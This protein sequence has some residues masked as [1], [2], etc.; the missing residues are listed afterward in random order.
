MMRHEPGGE[1]TELEPIGATL[2]VAW[3]SD[4]FRSASAPVFDLADGSCA[5]LAA[6]PAG[7]SPARVQQLLAEAMRKAPETPQ[8]LRLV[9]MRVMRELH[10]R[11]ESLAAAVTRAGSTLVATTPGASVV[12]VRGT[13]VLDRA[14]DAT[15]FETQESD[16]IALLCNKL[17]PL[18]GD[19]DELGRIIGADDP[20]STAVTLVELG[21][22]RGGG[23]ELSAVVAVVGGDEL[24]DTTEDTGSFAVDDLL[25][26]LAPTLDGLHREVPTPAPAPRQRRKRL[27]RREPVVP[28]AASMGAPLEPNVEDSLVPP[29]DA[30]EAETEEGSAVAT[31]DQ[32]SDEGELERSASLSATLT[33]QP[34]ASPHT[35]S[36]AVPT[37]RNRAPL[38]LVGVAAAVM[39]LT[40]L[41]VVGVAIVA[42]LV[43]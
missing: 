36:V 38:V 39:G 21:H 14:V 33:P 30:E 7:G 3:S 4:R 29:E 9:L 34:E 11:P 35:L 25:S 26:A 15:A 19:A 18:L 22:V 13:R 5:W 31:L 6:L 17:D 1:E 23:D 20:Q 28:R 8:Q 24:E 32:G 12:L 2:H 10:P 43:T 37:S 40:A 27:T 16:R 41:A 42:G